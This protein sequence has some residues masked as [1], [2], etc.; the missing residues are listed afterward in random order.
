MFNQI[1]NVEVTGEKRREIFLAVKEALQNIL[2][3]S[4][5]SRAELSFL[6]RET[7]G[8]I[9]VY[10]NGKGINPENLNRFGNG[11]QNMK[12]R[13]ESIGGYFLIEN[14]EGTFIRLGFKL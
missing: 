10:D 14:R 1:P 3:H 4:H 7:Q 8:E 11:L 9:L 13:M 2:K 12:Q 6:L 5:A